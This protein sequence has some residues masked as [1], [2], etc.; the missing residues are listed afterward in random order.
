[1]TLFLVP[2]MAADDARRR[3]APYVEAEREFAAAR[4]EICARDDGK[5]I[6]LSGGMHDVAWLSA[7]SSKNHAP[8]QRIAQRIAHRVAQAQ[9]ANIRALRDGSGLLSLIV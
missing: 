1:M 9:K 5:I 6:A 4:E 3:E 8:R 2:A 7:Q